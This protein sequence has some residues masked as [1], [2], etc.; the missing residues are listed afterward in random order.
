MSAPASTI[1]DRARAW[2]APWQ[3]LA[4]GWRPRALAGQ[5]I[6]PAIVLFILLAA[7]Q[8]YATVGHVNSLLLP[9]PLHVAQVTR[10]D[11]PALEPALMVTLRE[12]IIGF[13]WAFGLGV[14]FA[15]LLDLAPLARRGIYPLLVAS[16]SVPLIALAPILQLWFG[17]TLTAKVIVIVLYCFFPITVASLDGLA[18][19]DPEMVRLY[20]GFGASRWQIWRLVR[21]P[22]ALPSLFSGLRIAIAYSVVGAIFGEYVGAYQGVAVYMQAKQ[23]AFRIDLVIGAVAV[24]AFASIALF[25]GVM[26]L[27]RLAI[28]WF[29]AERK[30]KSAA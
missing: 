5:V 17:I 13:A 6:A 8:I 25:L 18:A 19:T 14:A 9:T 2:L 20:R 15:A 12:T 21:L 10:A 24:T 11:W 30:S 22:N 7:W 3:A 27:E 29:F 26:L 1:A 4:R 16:Q 23:H 28:P